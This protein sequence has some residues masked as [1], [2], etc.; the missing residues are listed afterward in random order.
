MPTLLTNLHPEPHELKTDLGNA[1]LGS[2]LFDFFR[3]LLVNLI[4]LD[5][6]LRQVSGFS[7]TTTRLTSM[8][9]AMTKKSIG[10]VMKK[11]EN[12]LKTNVMKVKMKI[13]TTVNKRR[14]S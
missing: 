9:T 11:D 10:I 2:L 8:T 3:C 5:C 6:L 14:R 13:H 1:E 12:K 7:A 4:R